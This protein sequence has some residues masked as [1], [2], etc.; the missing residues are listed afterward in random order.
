MSLSAWNCLSSGRE[1][2]RLVSSPGSARV[3]RPQVT[4]YLS[5]PS[6]RRAAARLTCDPRC[7]QRSPADSAPS[8][9]QRLPRL[10]DLWTHNVTPWHRKH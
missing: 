8:P 2:T 7:S 5:A 10:Q 9:H 6:W 3:P 4:A 1:P